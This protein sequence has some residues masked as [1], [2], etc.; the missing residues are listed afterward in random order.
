LAEQDILIGVLEKPAEK[1]LYRL[2]KELE[3]KKHPLPIK[4][5]SGD[6]FEIEMDLKMDLMFPLSG[7]TINITKDP[8]D[9]VIR[10]FFTATIY[11][12]K[13]RFKFDINKIVKPG[14]LKRVCLKWVYWPVK[15][16]LVP[17]YIYM[18]KVGKKVDFE[19]PLCIGEAPLPLYA[20]D[21][22][23]TLSSLHARCDDDPDKLKLKVTLNLFD[24]LSFAFNQS[25]YW[26]A[27][28]QFFGGT[29][30][31]ALEKV[32]V[33]KKVLKYVP[34]IC[35]WIAD[36]LKH[37]GG[38]AESVVHYIKFTLK[39]AVLKDLYK[40]I[41][42]MVDV[43]AGKID[44]KYD[45]A[46]QG[47]PVIFCLNALDIGVNMECGNHTELKIEVDVNEGS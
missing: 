27:I 47:K 38:L 12:E 7:R 8:P 5:N 36:G 20:V 10:G 19:I 42:L 11:A 45:L 34:E 31:E 23:V 18:P 32:P 6:Q 43:P 25:N 13:M 37:S 28:I 41:N 35:D 17:I 21:V 15:K 33:L 46:F 30:R 4:V 26:A 40:Y 9:G 1:L 2:L 14:F 3:G 44:R 16:C 24:T 39:D 22:E 29:I